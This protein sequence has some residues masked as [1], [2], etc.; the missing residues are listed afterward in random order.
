MYNIDLSEWPNGLSCL[1][2]ILFH[3]YYLPKK[4]CFL[5]PYTKAILYFIPLTIEFPVKIN[6]NNKKKQKQNI[7]CFMWVH[8]PTI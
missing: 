5:S 2:P 3:A 1:V 6:N 8:R 7:P 4:I